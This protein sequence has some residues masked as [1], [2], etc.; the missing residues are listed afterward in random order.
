MLPVWNATM[1]ENNG[2]A[3]RLFVKT[4]FNYGPCIAGPRLILPILL[5]FL[6][7]LLGDRNKLDLIFSLVSSSNDFDEFTKDVAIEECKLTTWLGI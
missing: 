1:L 5:H 2:G 6:V 3:F 7:F 4:Q